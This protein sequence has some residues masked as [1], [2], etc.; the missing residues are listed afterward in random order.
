[1][2]ESLKFLISYH[3]LKVYFIYYIFIIY[4]RYLFKYQY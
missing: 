3:K 4:S 2:F 1:M